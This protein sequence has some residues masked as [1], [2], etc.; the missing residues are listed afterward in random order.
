MRIFLPIL[1]LLVPAFS[2]AEPMLEG[3]ELRRLPIAL[4]RAMDDANGNRR[5]ILPTAINDNGILAGLRVTWEPDEVGDSGVYY[6]GQ[7][8]SRIVNQSG[9][10]Y[11]LK[12]RTFIAQHISQQLI[13]WVGDEHYISKRLHPSSTRWQTYRCPLDG[14]VMREGSNIY[15]NPDCELI[16]NDYLFQDVPSGT[17][18][19]YW[20]SQFLA[21]TVISTAAGMNYMASNRDSSTI[22]MD[23]DE[24]ASSAFLGATLN[25]YRSNGQ[26]IHE[27]ELANSDYAFPFPLDGVWLRA[28]FGVEDGEDTFWLPEVTD[29][30]SPPQVVRSKLIQSDEGEMTS[31]VVNETLPGGGYPQILA[32]SKN[33]LLLMDSGT[34]TFASGCTDGIIFDEPIEVPSG[35]ESSRLL[36]NGIALGA[37]VS[38]SLGVE[39][40]ILDA[41]TETPS[42]ISLRELI[43][44][45]FGEN[46]A[47]NGG[48]LDGAL[49][50][51][52]SGDFMVLAATTDTGDYRVYLIMSDE[53]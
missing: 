1:L 18:E 22:I 14:L 12:T 15:D 26:K 39:P 40:G 31:I 3:Y 51:S 28:G 38:S 5:L 34:C 6:A 29:G 46:L 35:Y 2:W 4:G 36:D 23:L 43:Q 8:V 44:A 27:S 53:E 9:Y 32:V 50:T 21:G 17:P 19:S 42:L 7:G 48:D 13:T 37:L 30:S 47:D 11:D 41:R 20:A 49:V 10:L 24:T 33:G 25:L 16:D 45:R 52:Q